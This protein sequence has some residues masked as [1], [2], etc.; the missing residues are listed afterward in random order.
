[1]F[2]YD[3]NNVV[4]KYEDG[5]LTKSYLWGEDVSGSMNGAG[6]VGGLLAVNDTT[7]NYYTMYD[8][9][10]NIVQYFDETQTSVAKFEY[11]PFGQ[12]KSESGTMPEAFN[13]RFSTKYHDTSTG[14]TVYRYRNYN[15]TL[16]KWQT[17]DPIGEKGGLNIYGFL[18]N[19]SINN[20]DILGLKAPGITPGADVINNPHMYIDKNKRYNLFYDF[21]ED[22]N[23]YARGLELPWRTHFW[24]DSVQSAL[25][26]LKS[27]F[28]KFKYDKKCHCIEYIMLSDHAQPGE[29]NF[30]KSAGIDNNFIKVYNKAKKLG[31]L[32][33]ITNI[34]YKFLTTLR[35]YLCKDKATV[36]FA[37]CS[38]SYGAKGKKLKAFLKS[39]F[40]KNVK[41][42]LYD[43]VIYMRYGS[44]H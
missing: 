19:D 14:L 21:A 33:K 26:H 4:A 6:G 43:R 18:G 28:K 20:Y 22:N 41:V 42:I 5:T 25:N 31:K 35:S 36:E 12:L 8:G 32:S 34:S 1:M 17:R 2:V 37:Q 13:Y 44:V 9:N 38:S 27:L 30:G 10:G 15:A 3:G 11:T 23:W 24:E 7:E 16:G 29:V 39:F 40:G